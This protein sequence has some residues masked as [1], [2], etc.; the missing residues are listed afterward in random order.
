MSVGF[1]LESRGTFSNP[2]VI[3]KSLITKTEIVQSSTHANIEF[4]LEHTDK[5]ICCTPK[6]KSA[7]E[8]IKVE[9]C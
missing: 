4:K 9:G 1:I 7:N 8:V 3:D 6:L 2:V 5:F